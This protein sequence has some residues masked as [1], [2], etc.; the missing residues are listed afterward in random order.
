MRRIRR[1][2]TSSP[3]SPPFFPCFV[4]L[5]FVMLL[6]PALGPEPAR[7]ADPVFTI[8]RIEP[9][10]DPAAPERRS[11]VLQFNAPCGSSVIE[12]D[13]KIL[14]PVPNR[15]DAF[16]V[17]QETPDSVSIPGRFEPGKK[18][19]V[20]LPDDFVCGGRKYSR[21]VA[22]FTMPD[23][24]SKVAFREKGSVVERDSR[25]IL[26]LSLTN[27]E[28]LDVRTLRLPLLLV[29]A[30][31]SASDFGRLRDL[32]S[33]R[34]AALRASLGD[35]PAFRRFLVEPAENRQAFRPG[36]SRNEATT[37]SVPLSFRKDREKGAA[38]AVAAASLGSG[39][40]AESPVKVL[41]VTDLGLATKRSRNSLLVW[42]T[43]LR[44][45]QPREGVAIVAVT[46]DG[47]AIPLGTT[48]KDGLLGAKGFHKLRSVP[49]EERKV[50]EKPATAGDVAYVL[51]ATEEDSA[52]LA[53]ADGG[54]V[55]DWIG[56][57]E[58]MRIGDRLLR[59]LVFTERGIYRPGE[60]VHFKGTV[61]AFRSGAVTPPEKLSV[62]FTV[63]NSKQEEV[64]RKSVLL[65]EF[66]TAADVLKIASH[67]P[68]GTYTVKMAPEGIAVIGGAPPKGPA[69]DEEGDPEE[70]E[71]ESPPGWTPRER[72][73]PPSR[74]RKSVPRGTSPPYASGS[75][76]GRTTA[77]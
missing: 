16:R 67:Y 58:P 1:P 35:D 27:V 30:A 73:R 44:T 22:S 51:A 5:L 45:G 10:I 20:F 38:L 11:V 47:F 76:S 26:N 50:P 32:S 15:G 7:A 60:S 61:R 66:G 54:L 62:A 9:R 75:R 59:G 23:L 12:E 6:L 21:T 42:A 18:Y 57:G 34:Y 55:A 69:V 24:P 63:I 37:F 74:C 43:S 40:E 28:E 19:T 14:P 8:T 29:P 53:I 39:R 17:L 71:G 56:P 31:S 72:S 52:F 68:L 48:G 41:C 64:F 4:P 65:S 13:L 77:T 2:L 70:E 25:Q 46:R 3:A 36:K 49:L 33:A